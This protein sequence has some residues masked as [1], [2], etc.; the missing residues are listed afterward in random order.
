MIWAMKLIWHWST[1]AKGNRYTVPG[2]RNAPQQT[3]YFL[4]GEGGELLGEYNANGE[5]KNEIIYLG[6]MPV[7]LN[8]NNTGTSTLYAIH[9]DHLGTP[10]IITDYTN[11]IVWSWKSDPFG[12][13]APNE[14][15]DNDGETLTFNLRFPGQYY[16]SETGLHYNYF[17]TYNPATGRYLESDPIGLEGGLNTYGYVGGNPLKYIDPTGEFGF[18][19][20]IGGGAF[21]FLFQVSLNLYLTDGDIGRSL[22]CINMSDILVSAA[23]GAIGPSLIGNVILG[24]AGPGGLTQAQNAYIYFTKSIPVGFA[25]K[26][27]MPDLRP[28]DFSEDDCEDEC[29]DLELTDMA[30]KFIQ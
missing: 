14:D 25:W 27:G 1:G 17:R 9:P 5:A 2:M 13:T 18:A 7:V 19:G 8:Q 30:S 21:N 15:P 28:N 10:R 23:M 6:G 12:N 16:D 3:V 26:K 4:Y 29:S 22:R 20:A 11:Q 24:R